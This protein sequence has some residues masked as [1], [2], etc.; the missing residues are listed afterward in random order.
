[1]SLKKNKV[2]RGDQPFDV[3]LRL[4]DQGLLFEPF[5]SAKDAALKRLTLL[6]VR[7]V[8]ELGREA[9]WSDLKDTLK[10]RAAGRIAYDSDIIV[11]ALDIALRERRQL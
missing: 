3:W 11:N 6:A 5:I 9:E 1:M 7:V 2:Y 10:T 4:S 8:D